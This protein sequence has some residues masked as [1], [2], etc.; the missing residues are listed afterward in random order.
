M[1]CGLANLVS[2]DGDALPTPRQVPDTSGYLSPEYVE[3]G[4]L[5]YFPLISTTPSPYWL[6]LPK[7][8][9]WSK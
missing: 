4:K 3:A 8:I 7:I 9:L 5:P 6:S 2:V 1:D